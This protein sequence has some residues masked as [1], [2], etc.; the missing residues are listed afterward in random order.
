MALLRRP[1]PRFLLW[2]VVLVGVALATGLSGLAW[3]WIVLIEFAA[4]ALVTLAERVI[5]MRLRSP[6]PLRRSEPTVAPA[7]TV[8]AE[9]TPTEPAIA[10]TPEPEP[11]AA[12]TAPVDQTRRRIG[13]PPI[14]PTAAR[15]QHRAPVRWNIWSLERVAR[16]HPESEELGYLVLSLREF[17]DAAGQL[18][19]DFDP[20]VRESF[21]DL[22]V[23]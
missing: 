21:G 22:L 12:T 10:V 5:S 19:A 3:W 4:W 14:R 17:A 15:Q 7:A 18:P 1:L 9:V 11:V 20:L 2:V 16:E 13:R 6:A 8:P 23:G